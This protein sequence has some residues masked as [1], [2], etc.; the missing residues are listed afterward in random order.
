MPVMFSISINLK[1]LCVK[2]HLPHF[3]VNEGKRNYTKW[4]IMG[5]VDLDLSLF[6]HF[7]LKIITRR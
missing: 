7:M 3:F 1:H 2:M 5:L 6:F 4:A